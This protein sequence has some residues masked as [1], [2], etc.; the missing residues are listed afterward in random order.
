[1][2]NSISSSNIAG[3]VLI[4]GLAIVLM[5]ETAAHADGLTVQQRAQEEMNRGKDYTAAWAAAERA[6]ARA[7]SDA[8][9]ARARAAE[10]AM[11]EGKD[12]DSAWTATSPATAPAYS[13]DQI[14]AATRVKEALRSGKNYASAWEAGDR[15][16]PTRAAAERPAPAKA[17]GRTWAAGRDGIS[18][19][20]R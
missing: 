4:A 16:P 2:R 7:Y 9:I 8:E 3:K 12:Y 18:T 14:A 1:M 11:N 17:K 13:P 20:Q 5:G 15:E 6:A 10:R 19:S